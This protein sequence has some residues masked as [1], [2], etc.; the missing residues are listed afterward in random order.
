MRKRGS[1]YY[2]NQQ[3]KKSRVLRRNVNRVVLLRNVKLTTANGVI[4]HKCKCNET[5]SAAALLTI[6]NR[7][8]TR[9][10]LCEWKWRNK[11]M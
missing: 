8:E 10:M 1:F 11:V 3:L 9:S 2:L 4:F 7:T 5:S 6:V